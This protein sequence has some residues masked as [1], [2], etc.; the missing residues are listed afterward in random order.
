MLLRCISSFNNC[1]DPFL[2]AAGLS[3]TSHKQEL[4]IE[5][6]SGPTIN[7]NNSSWSSMKIVLIH[8]LTN[9]FSPTDMGN[10]H[11]LECGFFVQ[12]NLC[13]NATSTCLQKPLIPKFS[14]F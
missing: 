13:V 12:Y 9:S 10:L 2:R 5:H 4:V 3:A 7:V 14:S 6:I 8:R 1:F 11:E